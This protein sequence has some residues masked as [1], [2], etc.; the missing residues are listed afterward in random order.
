MN[1]S[2]STLRAAYAD[3]E[4]SPRDVFAI[5]GE[6]CEQYRDH[7]IWIHQLSSAELEPYFQR[8][9][10]LEP[11]SLPLYGIPFAIKDNIDLAGIPTTAACEDFTYTPESSA[12]VV[13]RLIDAG[14]IPVGK[15]NLDQFATGLVGTRSPWGACKN[16]FDP[17]MVSGGSSAGSAV[18]VAL[19]MATFSLG[20]DTAGSGRVPACFNN[21][22]GVKPSIGLLSASGML[23]ACRS[24]DCI[25]IFA[26]QCDDA[27]A[28]LS[29]AEGEDSSD[30]YS[31]ANPFA[32]STRHYGQWQGALR[33]GVLPASQLAFFGHEGYEQ[34]YQQSL[35]AIGS[36]GV[37]LVEVDFSPFIEAARLLYEGPWVAERFIATSPLI[38]KRPEAL[39]D[40]TRTIISAGDKG[41]AVEAFRA[42]YRLKELRKAAT[43]ILASVD[44]LLTPTAARPYSIDEVNADPITLNS[45]LGYYTNYMNLFDLA[46]V[47]FPTGFTSSG[48]P[49]GLTLV[50]E[51]FTD[52]RL[53]SVANRLQQLF[54]LPLGKEQ[55]PYQQLAT[56][57][58]SDQQRI[59]VA[60]CGAHLQ[61]Q[62]LNWQLAERGAYLLA[63][64]SSAPDYKLYALAGGPPYRPGMV[65][66]PEGEGCAIELEVWSVP[67]SEFGSFVAGIPAPLGIGKVSLQDGSVV[68]GFI[69]EA[70]GLAGA[71]DIS[72][73][74]G[75]SKYLA[76]K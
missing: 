34:C 13:Q 24:L 11:T 52:R 70:S 64:T 8:L 56:L 63:K 59:A 5:I 7:N 37:E 68:S 55:S 31:R 71:E 36:Q 15:A 53:L 28:V 51:A 19:G 47:A 72:H 20:T 74:G 16:S 44:C 73:F 23:P 66:A 9:E 2:L 57:P 1:L 46:G 40:V 76:A 29:V 22:V 25:T 27:N 3:K 45:H 49:F 43:A 67:S 14:A 41:S 21:L 32:N 50:G 69:C 17:S 48:F 30:A 35:A 10:G 54:T 62:P 6:R 12:F 75:W 58:V 60:V 26:L 38:Q 61:G 33:M 18:S 39:L 65:V 4:L 42:Q